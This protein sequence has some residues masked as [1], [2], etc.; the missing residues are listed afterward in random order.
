MKEAIN[1]DVSVRLMKI[2]NLFGINSRK[3]SQSINVDPSFYNKIEKGEKGA[4][5]IILQKISYIWQ[6]NLSWLL[7]GEGP[8]FTYGSDSYIE[9]PER[10]GIPGTVELREQRIKE[11][12]EGKIE[13]PE[14]FFDRRKKE[15]Q[16]VSI[17]LVPVVYSSEIKKYLANF[18]DPYYIQGLKKIQLLPG[19]QPAGAIWRFFEISKESSHYSFNTGEFVL[20]SQVP[21]DD[22]QFIR[23]FFTYVI[24]TTECISIGEVYAADSET[25]GILYGENEKSVFSV[26]KASEVKELWLVRRH[27]RNV[28]PTNS[29]IDEL[30]L[31]RKISDKIKHK[32]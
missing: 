17:P 5:L 24:V 31:K 32:P 20:A 18:T 27:I 6:V 29:S 14:E 1:K 28:A 11:L 13:T 26:I 4:S 2:R 9:V 21:F 12:K 7:L 19:I 25:W 23:N 8:I 15:N 30:E 16:S 22:W 3:F 10:P